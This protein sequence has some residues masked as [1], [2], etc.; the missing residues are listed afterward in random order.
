MEGEDRR[1]GSRSL[2]RDLTGVPGAASGPSHKA[3]V[4]ANGNGDESPQPKAAACDASGSARGD[5]P[6]PVREAGEHRRQ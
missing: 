1:A 4:A 6:A 5:F 3:A 2:L